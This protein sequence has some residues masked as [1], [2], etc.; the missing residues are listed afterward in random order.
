MPIPLTASSQVEASEAKASTAASA[1]VNKRT[2]ATSQ[3]RFTA[4][5]N[6]RP[7]SRATRLSSARCLA[8]DDTLIDLRNACRSFPPLHRLGEGERARAQSVPQS[9]IRFEA[10]HVIAKTVCV[11]AIDQIAVAPLVHLEREAAHSAGEHGKSG[12]HCL[13]GRV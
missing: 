7:A 8:S 3:T 4:R 13:D 2:V 1:G 10:R 6:P 9:G 5:A 11:S 12:G